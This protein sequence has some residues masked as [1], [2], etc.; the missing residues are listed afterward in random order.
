MIN[1]VKTVQNLEIQK[2]VLN[3]IIQCFWKQVLLESVFPF[4][5][6]ISLQ[7]IQMHLIKN[8]WKNVQIKWFQIRLKDAERVTQIVLL[9]KL[10]KIH[11]D[12]MIVRT[13]W[14]C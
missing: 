10:D 4:K 8:V 6:V 14:Q 11:G 1:H 7:M 12:A 2:N 5:I 13:H 9:V 3:A